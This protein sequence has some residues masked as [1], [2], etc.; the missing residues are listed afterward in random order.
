MNQQ[1]PQ[2][3]RGVLTI[4]VNAHFGEQLVTRKSVALLLAET[5][6]EGLRELV[7]D[8]SGV[9]FIS[10]AVAHELLQLAI[11]VQHDHGVRLLMNSMTPAVHATIDAVKRSIASKT[12]ASDASMPIVGLPVLSLSGLGLY[13]YLVRG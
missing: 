6:L 3:T 7:L 10:R 2:S 11:Q 1:Q 5:E 12:S 13:N 9:N 8:F 4:S